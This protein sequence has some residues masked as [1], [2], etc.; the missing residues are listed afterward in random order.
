VTLNVYDL[1]QECQGTNKVLK[2][3]GTGVYHAG[4][5]V[6]GNE[7]SY[8]G[9]QYPGE[10][11]TGVYQNEEPRRHPTHAFKQSVAMGE[12]LFTEDEVRRLLHTLEDEWQAQDYKLLSHNC[13]DF[14]NEFCKRLGVGSVPGWVKSLA[15]LGA[16]VTDVVN[17][18]PH[19]VNQGKMRRGVS[20][21]DAY[22]VGDFTKGAAASVNSSIGRTVSGGKVARGS[23]DEDSYQ[24]G[25]FTRG[26]VSSVSG[27]VKTCL[28]EG[29]LARDANETD[30]YKFGDFTRGIVAS[31]A[32][33]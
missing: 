31:L 12:T 9:S 10:E 3:V 27:G 1:Q 6:Y 11:G 18:I 14:S 28:A 5:E 25:D 2:M 8:G 23:T 32:R 17:V 4:V 15:G 7:Y 24:F 33:K 22:R 26:L 21:D 13:C 19:C 16:R 20:T 30:S 29:K